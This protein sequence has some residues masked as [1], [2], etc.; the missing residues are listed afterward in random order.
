MARILLSGQLTD[1]YGI[2]IPNGTI[3]L[4]YS[5]DENGGCCGGGCNGSYLAVRVVNGVV[6][7]LDS[8]AGYHV[9]NLPLTPIPLPDNTL[10]QLQVVR[11]TPASEGRICKCKE[12]VWTLGV[13]D[14]E[15]SHILVNSSETASDT[16]AFLRN[17]VLQL[18]S[19]LADTQSLLSGYQ[20]SIPGLVLANAELTAELAQLQNQLQCCHDQ[21]NQPPIDSP[22]RFPNHFV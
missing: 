8:V 16:N 15:L 17:K 21:L 4:Y 11:I 19:Q 1:T 12:G 20:Q 2:V 7:A 5:F 22:L 13:G 6:Y 10:I 3:R 18:E 14:I 9:T